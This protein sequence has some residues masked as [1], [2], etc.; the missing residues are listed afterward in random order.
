LKYHFF[1]NFNCFCL[2]VPGDVLMD[3]A[4][5]MGFW[6]LAGNLTGKPA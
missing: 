4:R 5:N 6:L 1:D 2:Y 3:E